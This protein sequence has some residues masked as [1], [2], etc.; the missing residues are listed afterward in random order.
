MYRHALLPDLFTSSESVFPSP[1]KR[2][3]K[4][5]RWSG[6]EAVLL[7]RIFLIFPTLVTSEWSLSVPNP[8]LEF[9]PLRV[10]AAEAS[11]AP[12]RSKLFPV[13]TR[14]KDRHPLPPPS[15]PDK[16][17]LRDSRS[18]E[19]VFFRTTQEDPPK[20]GFDPLFFM[21]VPWHIRTFFP[22]SSLILP[23]PLLF[24]FGIGTSSFPRS[25]GD[26]VNPPA[27]S[28]PPPRMQT[29]EEPSS[30]G[31]HALDRIPFHIPCLHRALVRV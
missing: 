26:L 31:R 12:P 9:E 10:P 27:F 13:N 23:P 2:F 20:P 30:G 5:P 18:L 8:L 3:P 21:N 25:S 24:P 4:L 22:V 14:R 16:L 28:D 1:R 19:L 11:L 29:F 6:L 15:I 17:W 7:Q